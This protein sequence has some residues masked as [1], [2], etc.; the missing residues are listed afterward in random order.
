VKRPGL[1]VRT[2]KTFLGVSDEDRLAAAETPAQQ[3]VNAAISPFAATDIAVR[4]TTLPGYSAERGL[5]ARALLHID[6]GALTFAK[7]ESGKPTASADVLGMVFDKD[8]TEIA[9]L[10]TGLAA[11]VSSEAAQ[12]AI[13]DGIAYTLRIPIPRAGPYQVR[14]AVR[15][16][17]SGKVGTAGEFV[18]IPDVPG[19]VFALSGIVLRSETD[20]AL[21]G[22]ADRVVISPSQAVRVYK[23]GANLKYACEIYNATAPVQLA[24]S[25]WRGNERVLTGTPDTL[26]PPSAKD[27][28]FAASG[29]FKLGEALAPGR[30]VLQIAAQTTDA[31][32]KGRV[33]RALQQMDFEV[34][35]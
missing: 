30:Y 3:L 2:R 18:E 11:S 12:G 7:D 27:R 29:A 8:G 17:A 33:S 32:N 10:S 9:H 20:L 31:R 24:I 25:V 28:W 21:P 4:A 6:A 13:R 16:R 14:F 35:R 26:T 19:G 22:D 1:K 23:P 15:D 34:R 5:F